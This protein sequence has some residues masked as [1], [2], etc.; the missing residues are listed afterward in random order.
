[1]IKLYHGSTCD[2]Q[3][4]DL[5]I[6]KPNKDFGR[7]FYLSRDESQ[8]LE[9]AEYKAFQI[10][11]KPMVNIYEFDENVLNNGQL[12]VKTFDGYTEEW[13]KF[14]FDNRTSADGESTHSYD[15]VI[16]P[17]ANDKVGLQIRRYMESEITFETF[18]QRLQYMKGIT[19]QYFFGTEA[20]IKFLKKV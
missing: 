18:I 8:A 20:A 12:K 4:I 14:V 1:M 3:K 6:S 2:I 17:I 19:F 10:G 7:G 11:G 13:A 5:S 9:L 16:G 15:I